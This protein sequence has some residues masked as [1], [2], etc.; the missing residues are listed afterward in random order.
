MTAARS[1]LIAIALLCLTAKAG[2]TGA[3][4]PS[5]PPTNQSAQSSGKLAG[6]W[7]GAIALPGTPLQVRIDFARDADGVYSGAIEIPQQ[8]ASD[9]KLSSISENGSSIGFAIEG[10][11]GDPTFAGT[12]TGKQI[13]GLF[14]QGPLKLP[15][16][17]SRGHVPQ[18]S[19]TTNVAA[20]PAGPARPY[21]DHEVSYDNGPIH[22][23]GT[24]TLP[25]GTGPF[26]AAVLITGSGPQDR[27]EQI[28]GHKPFAIMADRLARAGIAVLRA[29]DRGVGGSF[30]G[31]VDEATTEELAGDT[32]AGVRFLQMQASIDPQRIGLIGHS[33]GGI[34]A[35]MLAARSRDIAFVVILA[36]S[37]VRGDE[38][39]LEQRRMIERANGVPEDI[40]QRENADAANLV[41]AIET[42]AGLQAITSLV[43][44]QLNAQANQLPAERRPTTRQ[45]AVNADSIARIMTTRWFRFFLTYDPRPTLRKVTVP[46]L[47]LMG[48]LDRQVS[49]AQNLP[50]I[51]KALRQA[52]NPDITVRVLPG[53]NHLFQKAG[54]GSPNEYAIIAE[55]L[56]EGAV[57]AVRGWLCARFVKPV[58]STQPG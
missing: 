3:T 22:L 30:G 32:L 55:D 45:T 40:I 13:T 29:D 58:S 46:V 35:P 18:P 52:G 4:G 48:D 28:L 34:I 26:P 10:V 38:V 20:V 49:P 51:E 17:L 50:E 42:G 19:P 7:E 9:L 15:F 16:T 25:A 5:T 23:A 31:T 27:D 2:S 11:L 24:L 56:N 36:G 37:G 54:T 44:A 33:E 21:I 43:Q 47:V 57:T 41:T 53:L 14:S 6:H 8:H 39:W 1:A 12:L